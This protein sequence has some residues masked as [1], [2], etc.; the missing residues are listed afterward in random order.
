MKF[1]VTLGG[2]TT[3]RERAMPLRFEVFVIEQQVPPELELD[4]MDAQSVHALALNGHGEAVGT[5]RLLPDA[6]IGR[7]AVR[8]DARGFG[9]GSAILRAL[10]QEAERRGE[11]AVLLHAQSYAVPFYRRFGFEAEGEEFM[12]AGIP[13]VLMRHCFPRAA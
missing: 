12:E 8:K 9:V 10:M 6:H 5:G 2:W 13:H 11:P 1:H 4:E 3:Q 7:M